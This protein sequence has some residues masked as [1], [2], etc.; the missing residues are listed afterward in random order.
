[1]TAPAPDLAPLEARRRR[2]VLL[3]VVVAVL[4]AAMDQTVVG[5]ALPRIARELGRLDLYAWVFS[6]YLLAVA[7]VVPIA[8]RLG[9]LYGRRALLLAGMALFVVGSLL[10]GLA[11][12]MPQLIA[13]RALQG[14]GAG[15]LTASAYAV[16]GDLYP[17]AELG[18]YNGL[19]TGVYGLASVIGPLV[20]GLITDAASWRWAFLINVPLCGLAVVPLAR[21]AP[22]RL[23][24]PGAARLDHAGIVLLTLTLLPGLLALS[25]LGAG[26]SARDPALLA[27]AALSLLSGL[28]L[29]RVEARAASPILP[30]T[31]LRGV[32]GLS[33]AI[34]FLISLALYACSI[35]LPLQLQLVHGL[36]AARAGLLMTPMVLALVAGSVLG[37]LQVTRSGRYRPV[38]LAGLLALG[39]A[40]ALLLLGGLAAPAGIS[41]ALGVFGLGVG[42]TLPALGLAAQNA[43]AHADLGVATALGRLARSVGGIVSVAAAGALLEHRVAAVAAEHGVA[44]AARL[45]AA[46]D[47]AL[48][49][50]QR[51]AIDAGLSAIVAASAAVAA[52]ALLCTLALRELPLRRT[53]ADHSAPPA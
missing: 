38:V 26:A 24:P 37:G 3:A 11:A 32:I 2:A 33:A 1:V 44:D 50:V 31:M 42:L 5:T 45:H 14:L 53:I 23:G 21:H 9:D 52:L 48:A 12:T 17:P 47:P 25:W 36:A 18:R 22:G 35:Y 8:G 41:A 4:L 46:T 29:A 39:L 28:A 49:A 40:L 15:V 51:Q 13:F 7:L 20:G 16:L 10:A 43:A 27:M 6:A 19:L 30:L 34:T